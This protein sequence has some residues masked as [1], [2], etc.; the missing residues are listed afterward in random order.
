[1]SLF[2]YFARISR[3]FPPSSIRAR[4]DE[5]REKEQ[6]AAGPNKNG[7]TFSSP[8]SS[9]TSSPPAQL[10]AD[11]YSSVCHKTGI[12]LNIP[13]D[14]ARAQDPPEEYFYTV[15]L[16]DEDHKFEG[17]Y[18][19]VQSKAMSCV[20]FDGAVLAPF[21]LTL[22]YP[23][24]DRLAFSKSIV[25][26]YLR[27]CLHR[28]AA[29]GAPWVVKPPIALQF[30]ISQTRT[31]AVDEKNREEREKVLA[32]RRKVIPSLLLAAAVC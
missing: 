4:A 2:R 20:H 28:D 11:D 13:P 7:H 24:R 27:E 22:A 21:L 29:I 15:Q 12:N 8:L 6:Q 18:M 9:I 10:A 26:R 14:D 17:S 5:E 19:E 23:S 31:E 3:V 16:M 32:K 30:G 1:M 25:K